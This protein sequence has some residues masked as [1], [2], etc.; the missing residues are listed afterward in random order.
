MCGSALD[1]AIGSMAGWRYPD[2]GWHENPV[3]TTLEAWAKSSPLELTAPLD[4]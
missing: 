1:F 3:T 4:S 2:F